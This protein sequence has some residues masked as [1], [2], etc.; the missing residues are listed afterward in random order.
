MLR[1]VGR[2]VSALS[3]GSRRSDLRFGL[4]R[5]VGARI[6]PSYRFQ[7]PQMKWWEDSR[8]NEYLI[9][10]NELRGMNSSR[11]WMLGQLTRLVAGVPGD[12]A[13]C[14][15]FEGAGS[16][17]ICQSVAA[18][19][20]PRTHYVFDSFEGLSAP[21]TEDGT[22]WA[23]GNL[24]CGIDIVKRNLS[25]FER[26]ELHKGWIPQAFEG[27]GAAT[28]A[29]VHIDV[30]LYEPT[31]DSMQF[32]YERMSSGGIIICDDYGFTT[33]P[34]ATKAVDEFLADK[35]EKMVSLPT[36]GGFLIKGV[37]TAREPEL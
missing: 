5:W 29:F 25:P 4:L 28:F 2:A 21:S 16:W 27:V 36:G 14:G 6:F 32:F 31:R 22:A 35:P 8:F 20:A 18:H 11:R 33:C 7:W 10:F 34:G 19:T 30:D 17:L 13:E 37:T 12:T 23:K 1:R 15:V 9:S 3:D 26:V 24:S